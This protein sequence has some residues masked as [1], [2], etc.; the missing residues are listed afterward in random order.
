[1]KRQHQEFLEGA[2][3]VAVV[4]ASMPA[5]A[6]DI[7]RCEAK[8]KQDVILSASRVV[9]PLATAAILQAQAGG[10]GKRRTN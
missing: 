8:D 9:M 6:K 4:V 3:I 5:A 7:I 1:M 2:L 10:T